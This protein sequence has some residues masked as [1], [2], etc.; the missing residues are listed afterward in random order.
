MDYSSL[1][2]ALGKASLFDL[3]RLKAAITRT[4]EDP[5]KNEAVR[6]N[7]RVGQYIG[8]F[9]FTENREILGQVI[10]I[11]RTR[12][13]IRH[14]HDQKLW[15]IPFY[16][17]NVQGA[18]TD[19]HFSRVHQK[20]NRDLL[21]VGD[22]VGFRSRTNREVYGVVTQLNRKTA[23]VKLTTGEQWRVAYGLLF[24]VLDA[25]A[26]TGEVIDLQITR[27]EPR[28]EEGPDQSPQPE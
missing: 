18:D 20:V 11:K 26:G 24:Y 23:T 19:T 10:E 3:W 17:L 13:L 27:D 9:D 5:Q 15:N 8:Y 25:Q 28:N 12:A 21:R 22:A 16:M 6:A 4:L 14:D 7:L 1:L 2:D